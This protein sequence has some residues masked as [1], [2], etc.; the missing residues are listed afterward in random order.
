MNEPRVRLV[1]LIAAVG[2]IVLQAAAVLVG[3]WCLFV[4]LGTA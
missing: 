1:P 4:W 3:V 2:G